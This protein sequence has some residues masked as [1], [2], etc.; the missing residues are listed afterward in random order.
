M[1][2]GRN[3]KIAAGLRYAGFGLG[4]ASVALSRSSDE[5]ALDLSRILQYG[6]TFFL[7]SPYYVGKAGTELT[8]ARLGSQVYGA[9]LA[10]QKYR[11]HYY[12]GLAATILGTGLLAL[13]LYG[14][15]GGG[16]ADMGVV[17]GTIAVG[18]FV[19]TSLVPPYYLRSAGSYL[20]KTNSRSEDINLQMHKVGSHLTTARNCKYYSIAAYL[21][22]GAITAY[23]VL[24]D[25]DS[26]IYMGSFILGFG[27]ISDLL[28]TVMLNYA[29][30]EL[31][32]VS[33]LQPSE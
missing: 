30:A 1:D 11:T 8:K 22:G 10:L 14:G 19:F 13:S 33:R 21:L 29:G 3:L 6:T 4:L 24:E 20:S 12:G 23:G 27:A 28:N 26:G 5:T 16:I 32:K 31:D 2:A 18:G 9:G 15:Y 25:D 17:W 7:I